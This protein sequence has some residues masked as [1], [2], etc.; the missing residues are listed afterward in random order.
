MRSEIW[1]PD[2]AVDEIAISSRVRLARNLRGHPFPGWADTNARRSVC[3]FLCQ[4][5]GETACLT[6]PRIIRMEAIEEVDR[7]VLQERHVISRE[8]VER[9]EGSALV[10]SEDDGIAVMVNEEDHLRLQA[11]AS[12]M[13]LCA[14]WERVDRL[15][16]ALE[17]RV[18]YA[19]SK[20]LGYLTACPSN[21]G[22]ALRAS[23]MLHLSGLKLTND[24]D[25]VLNG[26]EKLGY[27]V[28]GIMGEGTD[29]SGNL[30]QISNQ[31]TLGQ[32]EQGILDGLAAL[33]NEVVEH[34]RNARARLM[35]DRH[36][37]V[38]DHVARAYGTL[39][40]ARV[41]PSGE[42]IELL[43]ALRLGVELGLVR[44]MT[45]S[46][47]HEL[48]LLTQPGHLQKMSGS[49]LDPET[50]DVVRATL[51]RRRVRSAALT[52]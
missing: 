33:V 37:D 49:V 41:L 25:G 2:G 32:T 13:D 4:A 16:T 11:I 21:V 24:L 23:V 27:A 10:L 36:N 18:P 5:I 26:V 34:E 42:A 48:L 30:Y 44:H 19:F 50:R 52:G 51:V 45:A 17:A 39:L 14:V 46:R 35:E 22:T 6:H 9:C 43:C 12:G 1:A 8:L 40:H 28:R 15:D 29:A 3:E 31:G 38:L 47:V 20:T 7:S